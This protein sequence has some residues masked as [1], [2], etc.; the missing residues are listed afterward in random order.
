MRV[1]Q[2][3]SGKVAAALTVAC[4]FNICGGCRRASET[5]GGAQSA[6]LARETATAATPKPLPPCPGAPAPMLLSS[7]RTGHHKVFL[8][9]RASSSSGRPDDP[10]IGYC[11]YRSQTPGMAKNCPKSPSC[12]QVNVVPVASPRCVDHLVKDDTT[13]YYAALAINSA[14]NTGNTSEEAIA[15]VPIAGGKK[16]APSDAATYPACRAPAA[17]SQGLH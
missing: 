13:Y 2:A 17:S 14:G 5:H 10:R 8:S 11:L 1:F 4:L 15:E 3:T 9:W 12:E 6:P 7:G 16:T